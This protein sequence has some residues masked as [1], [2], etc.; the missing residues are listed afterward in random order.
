MQSGSRGGSRRCLVLST[1]TLGSNKLRLLEGR[2]KSCNYRSISMAMSDVCTFLD[3]DGYFIHTEMLCF[4]WVHCCRTLT[5]QFVHP[6]NHWTWPRNFS[7]L[8]FQRGGQ[9]LQ[10][11]SLGGV[12]PRITT[13]QNHQRLG[14]IR[15]WNN[16]VKKLTIKDIFG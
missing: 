12:H 11:R 8:S 9:I 13:H 14:L 10:K 1:D 6:G 7:E 16:M 3:W 2:K 5:Q 4:L 15:T